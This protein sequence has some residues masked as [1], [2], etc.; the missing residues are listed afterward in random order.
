MRYFRSKFV[1]GQDWTLGFGI[2]SRKLS[3]GSD[4]EEVEENGD[5]GVVCLRADTSGGGGRGDGSGQ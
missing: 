1:L 4:F 5:G 2:S 3:N